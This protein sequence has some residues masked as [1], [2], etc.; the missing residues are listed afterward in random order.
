MSIVIIYINLFENIKGYLKFKIKIKLRFQSP[1]LHSQFHNFDEKGC[2]NIPGVYD[3]SDTVHNLYICSLFSSS[4]KL[5]G[6]YY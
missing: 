4:S 3:L 2:T 6:R 1:H 5:N